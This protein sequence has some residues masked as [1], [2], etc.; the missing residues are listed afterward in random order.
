[1]VGPGPPEDP[2]LAPQ[3]SC[4]DDG[5]LQRG[6]SGAICRW[7]CGKELIRRIDILVMIHLLTRV[8]IKN[9][10]T[11]CNPLEKQ[12]VFENNDAILYGNHELITEGTTKLTPDELEDRPMT[13][14]GMGKG[15][16]Y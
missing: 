7:A 12:N 8:N 14:K 11:C 2:A 6:Q 13:A 3:R 10:N 5:S 15:D 4:L 16:Y 1:M 9:Y